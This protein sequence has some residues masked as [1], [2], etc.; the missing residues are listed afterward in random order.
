MPVSTQIF[1]YFWF[2]QMKI[3][4]WQCRR[5]IPK[6][7]RVLD[8]KY[9]WRLVEVT[10]MPQLSICGKYHTHVH[11]H[12]RIN[13]QTRALIH[14]FVQK[15]CIKN[16]SCVHRVPYLIWHSTLYLVLHYFTCICRMCKMY[17]I[18]NRWFKSHFVSLWA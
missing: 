6:Q 8:S 1:Q 18:I 9:Y 7:C 13:T 11:T 3:F 2:T 17:K 5:K 15:F 4:D 16:M 14:A 10:T 12:T